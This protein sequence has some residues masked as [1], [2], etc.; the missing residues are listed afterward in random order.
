MEIQNRY[1]AAQMR[2]MLT[3]LEPIFDVVRLVDP[4]DTA[5]LR[6]LKVGTIARE[7]YSCFRTWNKESRC[8]NC[9]SIKAAMDGCQRTKYEFIRENVFYVVSRPLMLELP[10]GDFPAVMEI[11]SHVSDQ[12]L[13]EKENGKSLAE[14][15][16]EIQEKLYQDELTR[17]F[18]R[19]YLNEFS[20][21]HRGMNQISCQ[22]GIIMLDLRQFKQINDTYGHLEGDRILTDVAAALRGRVRSTDSVI[23][24]GGDEF[25][26]TL[27]GCGEADVRRMVEELRRVVE[28]ITPADFGYAYAERFNASPEELEKMLDQADRRMYEE[29]RRKTE[30]HISHT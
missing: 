29:K 21:L 27:T 24:L 25:L 7:P 2:D 10:E 1:T 16:T 22:V 18:N 26:V 3:Y 11:V 9:T 12:L 15:L 4:A 19:R 14:R 5:V 6:L 28:A 30:E 13:L 8:T 23:R 20:F 17:V